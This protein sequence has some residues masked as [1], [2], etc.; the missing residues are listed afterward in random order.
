LTKSIRFQIKSNDGTESYY[1]I[2]AHA[3]SNT[4]SMQKT[5]ANI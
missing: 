3:K 5:N 4:P 1:K 2:Q